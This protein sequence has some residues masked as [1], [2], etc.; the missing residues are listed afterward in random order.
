MDN[1]QYNSGAIILQV[2]T[3]SFPVCDSLDDKGQNWPV[4]YIICNVSDIII[5]NLIFTM[6]ITVQETGMFKITSQYYYKKQSQGLHST[7]W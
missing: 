1:A 3:N 4:R 7:F 6:C 5:Y 2:T